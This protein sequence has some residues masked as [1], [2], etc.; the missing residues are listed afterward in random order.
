MAHSPETIAAVVTI[1]LERV[2]R[3]NR[4]NGTGQAA[5]EMLAKHL[6]R[7]DGETLTHA[8]ISYPATAGEA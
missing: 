5:K 1:A 4:G 7:I 2:A 6:A 3:E 8:G